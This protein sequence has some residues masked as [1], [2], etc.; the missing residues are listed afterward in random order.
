MLLKAIIGQLLD[1]SHANNPIGF[2]WMAKVSQESP[3]IT[4][5][6]LLDQ[7]H[8]NKPIGLFTWMA[9]VFQQSSTPTIKQLLSN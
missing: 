5:K 4:T 8:A 2:T 3:T 9:K 6:R 1:P 7:S